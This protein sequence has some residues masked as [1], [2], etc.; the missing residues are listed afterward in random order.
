MSKLS[1][2]SFFFSTKTKQ[3]HKS[4]LHLQMNS[5]DGKLFQVDNLFLTHKEVESKAKFLPYEIRQLHD[6]YTF[7]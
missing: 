4:Y 2:E 7:Q 6:L 3:N 5:Q 1:A